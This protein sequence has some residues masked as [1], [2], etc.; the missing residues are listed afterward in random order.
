M[1]D[2]EAKEQQLVVLSKR[3]D[4]GLNKIERERD[5]VR[6]DNLLAFWNLLATEYENICE[7]ISKYVIQGVEEGDYDIWTRRRRSTNL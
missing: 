3:L 6:R 1:I 5:P 4:D 2:I 7:E